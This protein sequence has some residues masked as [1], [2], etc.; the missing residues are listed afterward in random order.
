MIELI[1]S[2]K[3]DFNMEKRKHIQ[4]NFIKFIV[5]KYNSE[6]L[7]KEDSNENDE[8][9]IDEIDN[10]KDPKKENENDKEEDED[11]LEDLIKEYKKLEK[12]YQMRNNAN[13]YNKRK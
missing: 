4:T 7:P 10:I 13:Y 11:L 3:I 8:Q 1:Q 5:E 12:N 2:K 9:I 6:K